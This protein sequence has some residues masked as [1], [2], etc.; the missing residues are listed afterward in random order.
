VLTGLIV[1]GLGLG[2]SPVEAKVT[3]AVSESAV[4]R[5][6]SVLIH[7]TTGNKVKS[8]TYWLVGAK[9]SRIA[10][11]KVRQG[12]SMLRYST[13]SLDPGVYRVA[14][15]CGKAGRASKKVTV[16]DPSTEV[17]PVPTQ[18]VDTV[19]PPS[20]PTATCTVAESG[21]TYRAEN[22]AASVGIR[23][24]NTSPRFDATSGSVTVDFWSGA[25]IVATEHRYV[26]RIPAGQSVLVGFDSV[27]VA[28][29]VSAFTVSPSCRSE[30]AGVVRSVI[31]GSGTTVPDGL[32]SIE[33]RGQFVNTYPFALSGLA[34]IDYVT[35]GSDGKVNGGGFTF[36]FTPVPVGATRG[37][38]T[39]NS[40]FS[41]GAA[42]AS[43][44]FTVEPEAD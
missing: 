26:E 11:K 28:S 32:G 23:L 5:G 3:V 15:K 1:A 14:V 36:T 20:P 21:G 18:P 2:A 30:P 39:Y 41:S 22:G 29:P 25:T 34:R 44:E 24:A 12:L 4:V 10:K 37:W 43:V 31:V 40:A 19:T 35:R 16:V 8:C 33:V 38:Q 42:P 9:R 6:E 27:S 7:V 13:T 17:T